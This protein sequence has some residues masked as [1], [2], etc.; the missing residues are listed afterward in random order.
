MADLDDFFAKKDKKK[1]SKGKKYTSK[2][3]QTLVEVSLFTHT[4]YEHTH[5][6]THPHS[7]TLACLHSHPPN[8]LKMTLL[9]T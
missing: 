5:T 3:P 1:K 4:V 8:H 6:R 2:T 9:K 7:D